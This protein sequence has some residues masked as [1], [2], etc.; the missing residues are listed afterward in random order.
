LAH[1][2]YGTSFTVRSQ[3][4]GCY[5]VNFTIN[6]LS[7]ARHGRASV[8]A[9]SGQ[10]TVF[11]PSAETE[12]TWMPE[13][14]VLSLMVP[15]PALEEHF[16]RLSG[17]GSGE[18]AFELRIA[19]GTAHLLRSLIGAALRASGGGL[20]GIPEAISWQMR[21]AI[22]TAMLLELRHDHCEMLTSPPESGI[23]RLCDAA[24]TLMRRRLASPVPVPRI[25]AELGVSERFL[26][27]A[28]RQELHTTPSARFKQLRL[29]A[30]HDAL[31]RLGPRDST[32][33]QVAADVGG[34]F[35][36]GRFAS[37]YLE[38][39]GELP[40]STL[41]NKG[42]AARGTTSVTSAGRSRT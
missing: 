36:L 4:L 31:L 14:D 24:T 12:L 30:V 42:S 27:V 8:V 15:K 25:A 19:D 28:F 11:S 16:R 29:E 20:S 22:L 10:A 5:L 32:I 37:E 17:I 40:S 13:T 33:T 18:L 6:G 1:F 34:F 21:D 38:M 26:Q 2:T 3:P 9:G 23:K 35:H 7:R 39:F 41:A